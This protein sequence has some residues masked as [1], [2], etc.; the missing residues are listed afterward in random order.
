M[1]NERNIVTPRPRINSSFCVL[2]F[3]NNKG[4]FLKIKVKSGC[5]QRNIRPSCK[6]E[7]NYYN[8]LFLLI[9]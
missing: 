7:G 3:D 6:T 4:G 9:E 8:P 1:T 2:I 5:K